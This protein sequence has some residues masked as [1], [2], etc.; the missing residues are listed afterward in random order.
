MLRQLRFALSMVALAM[1]SSCGGGVSNLIGSG[2]QSRGMGQATI[3]VNWPAP[4]RTRLI[5]FASTSLVVTFVDKDG[6]TRSR[7]VITKLSSG[8]SVTKIKNLPV[9]TLSL[10]VTAYPEPDGTGTAQAIGKSSV[11][12]EAE[13][14]TPVTVSPDSTIVR[15]VM[16][17]GE[18]DTLPV[19][20]GS[21]IFVIG[22]CRDASDAIVLTEGTLEK[23]ESSD[24]S[25]ATVSE[26]LVKAVKNGTTTIKYTETESGV[27]G[28][29]VV[30]VGISSQITPNSPQLDPKAIQVFTISPSAGTYPNGAT[31]TWTLTGNGS[32]GGGNSVVTTK[33]QITYTAPASDTNDTLEVTVK[34]V[35]GKAISKASTTIT[36]GALPSIQFVISGTWDSLT[37][38]NGSYTF[39]GP[40]PNGGRGVGTPTLDALGVAYDFAVTNQGVGFVLAVPTGQALTSQETFTRTVQGQ[41]TSAGQFFLQLASNLQ[42]PDAPNTQFSVPGTTGNLKIDSASQLNNGFTRIRFTFSIAN[43]SGGTITGSGVGVI[44]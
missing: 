42:N 15:V 32:L 6:K 25:I 31:F 29:L 27:T 3:N 23:W 2:G 37:P 22:S 14:D 7:T 10:V 24:T 41:A 8:P 1:L 28:S 17:L 5:P 20:V 40:T 43:G 13:K 30:T 21:S 26:G 44:R 11:K 16:E 38:P 33:P 9:G 19:K 36:V 35:T 39:D 34:D 4:S 12:I 18:G